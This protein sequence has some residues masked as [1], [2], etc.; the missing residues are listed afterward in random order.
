M[1][2][3]GGKTMAETLAVGDV[4]QLKSGGESMTV[5]AAEGD[6]V[7]CVWFEGKKIQK[8]TLTAGALKKYVP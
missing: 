2:F 3:D 5:E 4:V 7:W 6:R 1:M 8:A